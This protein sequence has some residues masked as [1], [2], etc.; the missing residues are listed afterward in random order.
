M[1]FSTFLSMYDAL[2]IL[3][4]YNL[5][6]YSC[7]VMYEYSLENNIRKVIASFSCC[8]ILPEQFKGAMFLYIFLNT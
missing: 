7:R 1:I 3:I 8:M 4:Y 5:S 6:M 2:T